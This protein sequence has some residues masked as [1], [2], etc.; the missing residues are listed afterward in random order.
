[1]DF[2]LWS[3]NLKHEIGQPDN[4]G[5]LRLRGPILAKR[6]GTN[7]PIQK[8]FPLPQDLVEF[9]NGWQ[10]LTPQIKK[11]WQMNW[12]GKLQPL[13]P[14]LESE[15][16]K[17]ETGLAYLQNNVNNL[18]LCKAKHLFE[19]EARFGVRLD[20][21]IKCSKESYFYQIEFVRLHD[22]VGL[23]LEANGLSLNPSGLLQLGGESRA[24]HYEL[25]KD[26]L[27]L[28]KDNRL[29]NQSLRFK[30]YFA[31]PTIFKQGWLPQSIKLQADDNYIG[32]W[33]GIEVKLVAAA[34]GKI[35]SIGG[36]DISQRDKQRLIQRAVPAGSVYF[37][38]VLDGSS[39]E[40]VFKA[41]DSKCVSD[42]DSEIGFGFCYIGEW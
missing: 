28:A 22:G 20:S 3:Q 41:F 2:S 35:Q 4:F 30:I 31:A 9:Q 37:F 34:L 27:D 6:N 32:N 17:F 10:I 25:V 7:Q 23:L 39:S 36:R 21:K 40:K 16:K 26:S 29:K 42:V 19:R 12:K 11:V 13:L 18:K 1:F 5:T 24:A 14:P 33:Q 15:P 8:L 38:E